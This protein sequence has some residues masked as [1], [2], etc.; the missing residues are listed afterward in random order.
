MKLF[1]SLSFPALLGG[2]ILLAG[3]V[4]FAASPVLAR[5]HTSAPA[6]APVKTK[7]AHIL[8]TSKGRTLYVFAADSKD[9]SACYGECAKFWPPRLVTTGTTP[10]AKVKGVPGTFGVFT[11]TDGTQQ[12]TYDGAPLYTFAGD[13]KAGDMNGQGLLA[14]GGF[15]WAVVA[16]GK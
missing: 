6:A 14:S 15:W 2:S 3:L 9:K 13:K 8:A 11:R 16:G 1:R 10:P 7:A 12:L 4:T 5:V